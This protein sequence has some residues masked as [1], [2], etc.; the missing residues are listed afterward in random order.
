MPNFISM[1][2]QNRGPV[3]FLLHLIPIFLYIDDK[4]FVYN[5]QTNVI[6]SFF[7]CDVAFMKSIDHYQL[8]IIFPLEI[9]DTLDTNYLHTLKWLKINEAKAT[10][11]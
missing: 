6:L 4:G 9:Y 1:P 10:F 5:K 2:M 8:F 11:S 3:I 7:Y